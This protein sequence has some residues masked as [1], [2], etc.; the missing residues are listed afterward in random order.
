MSMLLFKCECWPLIHAW[1]ILFSC[2]SVNLHNVSVANV[3]SSTG[4]VQLCMHNYDQ[5]LEWL[6]K[7]YD[8]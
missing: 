4:P 8:P 6:I 5:E 2:T 7:Q 3:K 1:D